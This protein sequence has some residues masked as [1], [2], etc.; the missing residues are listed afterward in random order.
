MTYDPDRRKG[1]YLKAKTIAKVAHHGQV[2][3]AGEDYVQGH[4][5]RVMRGALALYQ[6][7]RTAAVA[8]L[9]DI[10]EDTHLSRSD[11]LNLGVRDGVVDDVWLLT[12]HTRIEPNRVGDR[13]ETYAEYIDRIIRHRSPPALAVKLADVRDH[14]RDTTHIPDSLV[15][16]YERAR[17]KLKHAW[18]E[19]VGWDLTGAALE[20]RDVATE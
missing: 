2:D 8:W 17:E 13:I 1:N 4:L 7:P 15:R 10:L 14:L 11:L 20:D 6:T 12:R 5:R 16:R 9:H 18:S 3:K 19:E